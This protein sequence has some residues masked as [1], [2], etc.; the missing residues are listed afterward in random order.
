MAKDNQIERCENRIQDLIANRHVPRSGNIDTVLVVIE[1]NYN[2]ERHPY[3]L[4]KC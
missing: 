2:E 4:V 3:Y 1:K